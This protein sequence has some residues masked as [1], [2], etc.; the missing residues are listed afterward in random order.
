MH[1]ISK[2]AIVAYSA[3]KMYRLVNDVER[4]PEFL[5][6]CT[7]TQ[8]ISQDT[9]EVR[10]S[11]SASKGPFNQTF[12]TKN[13]LNAPEQITMELIDGP[14]K[15]LSG[16]WRF[17]PLSDDACKVHFDL[18]FGFATKLL[19]IALSPY[20]R[21]MTEQQLDAFISRAKAVYGS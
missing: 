3:E 11:I 4:Y 21:Q 17:I 1:T 19:D 18:E 13:T 14:F 7:S 5:A 2:H 20:F 12:S 10:A 9:H 8:I 6:W 16:T 15:H